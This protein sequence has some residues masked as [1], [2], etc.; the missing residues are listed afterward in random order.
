MRVDVCGDQARFLQPSDNTGNRSGSEAGQ[1]RQISRRRRACLYKEIDALS[2][3][4]RY[5]EMPRD[6]FPKED[7]KARRF[8][9]LVCT[10]NSIRIDEVR[11]SPN[12]W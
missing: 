3:G 1:L 2:V 6:Q 4:G 11:E 5:A 7:R 8:S 12:L 9:L 10:E